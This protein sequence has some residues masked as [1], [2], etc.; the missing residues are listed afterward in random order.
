MES[1]FTADYNFKPRARLT[2]DI[3]AD[4]CV[5]GG[6]ICGILTA[7]RLRKAGLKAV[8]LEADRLCLGQTG[9]TTAK[10]TAHHGYSLKNLTDRY[11]EK[12]ARE[13]V[14]E[15]MRAVEDFRRIVKENNI[16]CD[17]CDAD[18]YLY[19]I[20]NRETLE[21]EY[22][23]AVRLGLDAELTNSVTL[24]FSTVGAVRVA[25]QA[26]FHPLKFLAEISKDLTVYEKTRVTD[27]KGETVFTR[28]GTVRAKHIVFACHFPIINFP[29]MYF[30][31]MYQERSYVLALKTDFELSGMYIGLERGTYSLRRYKDFLLFGGG[32]HRAGK[33][34]EGS[35][36]ECLETAAAKF[37]PGNR[38]VSRWSAQDCIP[39]GKA[40]LIGRY[41]ESTPNHYVATGFSKW[42]MTNSMAAAGIITGLITG[43]R[44]SASFFS[45]SAPRKN[46]FCGITANAA[47]S[48]AGL[49]AEYLT[50]PF[51]AVSDVPV[52]EGRTVM[53]K[54]KK[55]GV[56][57]ESESV[58]HAVSTKCPHLGCQLSWNKNEKTW[59]CPCHGSRFDIRGRLITNPAVKDLSMSC[60]VKT[61]LHKI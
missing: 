26:C 36:Y 10:I 41:S 14:R 9:G 4:V 12:A 22:R 37:F 33:T 1:I 60:R 53:Y 7:Y 54:G 21:E 25:G 6:G 24:P 27:V 17:F 42:G 11:G 8:I 58:F 31:K 19:S 5:I 38:V 23:A 30:I 34:K 49:A 3:E 51:K 52:G 15:N 29:G 50:L 18:N 13:Y 61:N 40:P 32:A 57:R 44:K 35:G 59:D 20:E 39:S 47:V 48:A 28:G 56:Y 43:Q 2:E 45:P 16:D 55:V 46:S